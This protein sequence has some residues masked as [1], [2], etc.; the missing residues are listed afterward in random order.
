MEKVKKEKRGERGGE[1]E[2]MKKRA[3]KEREEMKMMKYRA[4]Q[5]REFNSYIMVS[6][7]PKE[8]AISG[9]GCRRAKQ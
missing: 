5:I 4:K 3:E 9:N 8:Q 2:K 6:R 1:S 7:D